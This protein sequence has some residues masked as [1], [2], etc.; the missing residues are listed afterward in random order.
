MAHVEL[1]ELRKHQREDPVLG[2]WI[3]AVLDKKPPKKE[4][5]ARS[6]QHQTMSRNF[7]SFTVIRGLLYRETVENGEKGKQ[8]VL[9]ARYKHVVLYS[10]HDDM[11]HPA[12]ERTIA[13][14]RERFD[15]PGY[16][17]EVA[18]HVDKCPRCLRRKSNVS[19]A[20]M[21]SIQSNYPLDLVT[22]EFLKVDQCKGGIGNIL[23]ITDH[24]TKLA[25]AV[26]TSNQTA[27]TTADVLLNI[28]IFKYGIPARLCY[29]IRDQTL[30]QLS[31]KKCV[32][33]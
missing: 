15:W 32:K 13:M 22:T 16:T 29:L 1:R 28:F 3:R 27:K 26:P 25:V 8:I 19:R 11:G 14:I 31:F 6:P 2:I 7:K 4:V 30:S 17:V 20:P 24:F 9:P 12:I 5:I 21:I 23:V 10:L 18:N 33:Y